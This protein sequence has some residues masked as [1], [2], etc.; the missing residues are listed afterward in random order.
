MNR[1]TDVTVDAL[2]RFGDALGRRLGGDN[3]RDYARVRRSG[4]GD[5][6]QGAGSAFQRPF[7]KKGHGNRIYGAKERNFAYGGAGQLSSDNLVASSGYGSFNNYRQRPQGTADGLNIP[8]YGTGLG[9]PLNSPYGGGFPGSASGVPYG[10]YPG[11]VGYSPDYYIAERRQ[12]ELVP[13]PRPRYIP[14]PVPVPFPVDRPVPQPYPV[15]VFQPVPVDR[16]VPVPISSPVFID[17][18]VAVPVPVPSPPPP[19]V[20]VPYPVGV[21]TPA[22]YYVPV[23]VPVPSPV[24]SPV[25][26]E[27]KFSHQQRWVAGAPAFG[28]TPYLGY[29]GGPFLR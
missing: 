20:C 22:P 6:F 8:P 1:V 19:P 11:S 10:V 14:Q 18:P 12:V 3:R 25:M 9:G 13:A 5:M 16:P 27:Q 2:Q 15:E 4:S 24:A 28:A 23:G 26:F 7:D 17:R 29:G 21:P